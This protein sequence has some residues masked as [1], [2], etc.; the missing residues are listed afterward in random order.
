MIKVILNIFYAICF[1][2]LLSGCVLIENG[3][4]YETDL[5]QTPLN[6]DL[7]EKFINIDGSSPVLYI[8][9]SMKFAELVQ[10]TG[11]KLIDHAYMT[12]Q[13]LPQWDDVFQRFIDWKP[14]PNEIIELHDPVTTARAF[15]PLGLSHKVSFMEIR[16]E[17]YLVFNHYQPPPFSN[18]IYF[19]DQ[20]NV[21]KMRWLFKSLNFV[22][23]Q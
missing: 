23:V 4:W 21:V 11:G 1:S 5:I 2:S 17:K 12:K 3:K 14:R 15:R 18:N 6:S 20:K 22:L 9:G 19:Y 13:T 7:T 10:D 16:G 8:P